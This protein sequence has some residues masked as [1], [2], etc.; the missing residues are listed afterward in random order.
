MCNVEDVT[1]PLS[2][3][4]NVNITIVV[5]YLTTRG[6]TVL[7]KIRGGA[8]PPPLPPTKMTDRVLP[9]NSHLYTLIKLFSKVAKYST[10][11]AIR[12]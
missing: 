9:K 5:I 2:M 11:S 4:I 8:Q 6:V 1:F 10:D 3:E 12:I 7:N